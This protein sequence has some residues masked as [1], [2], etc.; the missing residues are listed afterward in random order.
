MVDFWEG[1]RE[2]DN[3]FYHLLG[4]KY[5]IEVSDRPDYLLYSVY[6]SEHLK[7]PGVR[8]FYTGENQV[9][10]FNLCDYAL[11]Y[12]HLHFGDRYKRIPLYY[13]HQEAMDQS[14]RKVHFT[15]A[16]LAQKTDFCNFL[17][18][19]AKAHPN[20]DAMFHKLAAYR[21]VVSGGK[22]LNNTGARVVDKL[23]F[24]QQS[25]FT[26]AFENSS[27]P[28]YTTE[29]ILHAFAAQTVP[30]YWGNPLIA[31]EFNPRAFINC[32]NYQTLDQVV[33]RVKQVDQDNALYLSM[34]QEELTF[35]DCRQEILSFFDSIFSQ[36]PE[37]AFRRDRQFWGRRYEKQRFREAFPKKVLPWQA[38]VRSVKKRIN[39][40]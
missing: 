31:G 16:D 25:K 37:L 19:N 32:H 22:H 14:R 11:G 8:I 10:D 17:Y 33:E 12:H 35:P 26:I 20:R 2:T 30:I 24:Q 9:P 34:M 29:K 39:F 15:R 40:S 7:Y 23:A 3:Y 4:E 36:V 28:G 27:H 38:A 6:G 13:L 18:S 21:H 5:R 1:F